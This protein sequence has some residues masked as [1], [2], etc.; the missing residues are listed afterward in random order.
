MSVPCDDDDA[1][2]Q[3][4]WTWIMMKKTVCWTVQISSR[5]GYILL[6]HRVAGWRRRPNHHRSLIQHILLHCHR[7]QRRHY[8]RR[9]YRLQTHWQPP[10]IP[11]THWT[12]K[13]CWIKCEQRQCANNILVKYIRVRLATV[14][15][16]V[17][18]I[19][20]RPDGRHW[21]WE[22]KKKN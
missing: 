20:F 9:H 7:R 10:Q 15:R 21:T 6:Q 5:F 17:V 19:R 12:W 11:V 1:G 18:N 16:I 8:R 13:L 22:K 4:Q 2:A 3:H 14:L